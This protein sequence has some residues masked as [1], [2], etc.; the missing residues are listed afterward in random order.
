MRKIKRLKILKKKFSSLFHNDNAILAL[1]IMLIAIGSS[2]LVL[3]IEY[4]G[5]NTLFHSF[6]DAIWWFFVTIFTVGYGDRYPITPWGRL[7]G[8]LVMFLGIGLLS[9][10]TGRIASFLVERNLQ[11]KKGL[12]VLKKLKDHIIICGWKGELHE[13]IKRFFS[14]QEVEGVS[15]VLINT[16]HQDEMEP[17]MAEFEQHDLRFINGDYMDENTLIRAGVKTASRILLLH[18]SKKNQSPVLEDPKI[19]MAVM[20]I[21]RLNPRIYVVAE[22]EDE[23][24][25]P[26]LKQNNCDEIVFAK[27]LLCS[28]FANSLVYD[29]FP[30]ILNQMAEI[31]I[32]VGEMPGDWIGKKFGELLLLYQQQNEKGLLIGVLENT[33]NFYQRKSE[34]IQDAQKTPNISRLV[35]NLKKVKVLTSNLPIFNPGVDYIIPKGSKLI[36]LKGNKERN[37]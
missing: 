26:Y 34:A 14:I 3:K 32:Q 12:A 19:V 10:T 27:D 5:G 16:A 7:I 8:I 23:K 4:H 35:E 24:F 11:R 18:E 33:G 30:N 29:G 21:K 13:I 20:T 36:I 31:G 2:Y 1:V 28:C 6:W 25:F 37:D 17:L 22:I 15:L 9:I